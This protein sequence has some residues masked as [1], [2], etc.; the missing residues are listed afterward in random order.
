MGWGLRWVCVGRVVVGCCV[1][2]CVVGGCRVLPRVAAV[3][4]WV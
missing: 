4:G 1:C 2:V 3:A